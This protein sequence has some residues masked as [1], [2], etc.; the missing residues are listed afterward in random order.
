M[1]ARWLINILV[2]CVPSFWSKIIQD[3]GP[4][5]LKCVCVYVGGLFIIAKHQLIQHIWKV[6]V[7]MYMLTIMLLLSLTMCT[8]VIQPLQSGMKPV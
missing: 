4:K 1:Y 7:Y 2:I 8:R 5:L 6:T 3:F